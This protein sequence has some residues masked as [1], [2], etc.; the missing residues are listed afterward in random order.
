[1]GMYIALCRVVSKGAWRGCVIEIQVCKEIRGHNSSPFG[2]FESP[3]FCF[4]FTKMFM[5]DYYW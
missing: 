4:R 2:L 3:K 1:M 5:G